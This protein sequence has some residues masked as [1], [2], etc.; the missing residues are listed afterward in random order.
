MTHAELC[1]RGQRILFICLAVL[2][3]AM[4]LSDWQWGGL[5]TADRRTFLRYGITVA[6]GVFALRGRSWAVQLLAGLIGA[7]VLY[8]IFHAASVGAALPRLAVWLIAHA[9]LNVAIAAVLILSPSIARY[10]SSK[11]ELVMP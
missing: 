4:V 3:A 10:Q 9:A 11:N 6:L 8:A 2:L 7:G 1:R 5:L